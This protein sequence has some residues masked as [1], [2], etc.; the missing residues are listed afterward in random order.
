LPIDNHH[1]YRSPMVAYL[2]TWRHIWHSALD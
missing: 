2:A 1:K